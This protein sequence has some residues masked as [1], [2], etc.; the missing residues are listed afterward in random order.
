MIRRALIVT[1]TVATV[2]TV[3]TWIASYR[4]EASINH[5]KRTQ[6]GLIIRWGGAYP[7]DRFRNHG[8]SQNHRPPCVRLAG[9]VLERKVRS[10]E[11]VHGIEDFVK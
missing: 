9:R 11:A 2:G 3:A 7:F 10:G 8:T 1:L 4:C 6:W 5:S